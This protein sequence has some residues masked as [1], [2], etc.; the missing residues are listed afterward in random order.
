MIIAKPVMMKFDRILADAEASLAERPLRTSLTEAEIKQLGDYFYAS[1]L[2]AD[3]EQRQRG[4]AEEDTLFASVH[5]QLVAAGVEFATPFEIEPARSGQH[6]CAM[7]PLLPLVLPE[8]PPG[9][10]FKNVE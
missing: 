2:N 8:M 5:E 10:G 6:A 9:H 1:E 7:G 3:E 4:S